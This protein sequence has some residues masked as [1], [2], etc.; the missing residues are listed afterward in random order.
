[1]KNVFRCVILASA[2][3]LCLW[4]TQLSAVCR[5]CDDAW[6]MATPNY[7][8][9]G[10]TCQAAQASLNAQVSA[11]ATYTCGQ[12]CGVYTV[13]TTNCFY[14]SSQGQFQ[15]NGYGVFSCFEDC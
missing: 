4:A 8:G 6:P 10:A 7:V 11:Y 5:Y 3:G 14:N 13:I 9:L 12:P 2:L 15:M 1:M